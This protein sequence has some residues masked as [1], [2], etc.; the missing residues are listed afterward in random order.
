MVTDQPMAVSQVLPP[1][2]Q[3][4]YDWQK[5]GFLNYFEGELQ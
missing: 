1:L 3:G 4:S 2:C 5:G